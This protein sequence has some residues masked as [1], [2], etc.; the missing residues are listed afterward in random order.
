MAFTDWT[1]LR[2]W[3]K[4]GEQQTLVFNCEDYKLILGRSNSEY[5]GMVINPLGENIIITL[6]MFENVMNYE[7]I[8]SKGE[9]VM[10]G[11]TR[12]YPTKMVD[13]LCNYFSKANKIDKAYLLWMV[14][15][16]EGSYLL[17]FASPIHPKQ[18]YP[19]IAE[20]CRPFLNGKFFDIVSA[21]S[22]FG[23]NAIENQ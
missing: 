14:R 10:V 8:I 4:E 5:Y 2:K 18:L 1:E 6:A 3:N 19:Q 17:V 13:E 21:S 22:D 12:E 15:G 16:K 23:K 11:I 20:F 9:E 7:Q